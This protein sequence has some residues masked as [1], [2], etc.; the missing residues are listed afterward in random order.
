MMSANY[1]T[2]RGKRIRSYGITVFMYDLM[3]ANQDNLC[4]ICNHPETSGKAMAI[5]HN[6]DIP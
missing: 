2:A 1:K 4:A 6:H 3:L 5:D